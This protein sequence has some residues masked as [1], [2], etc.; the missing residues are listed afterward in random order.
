MDIDV[1]IHYFLFG[2]INSSIH[3]YNQISYLDKKNKGE[4][5]NLIV[6]YI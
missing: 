3:K 1:V 2:K 4:K 6:I 5:K